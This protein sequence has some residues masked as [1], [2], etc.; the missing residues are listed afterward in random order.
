MKHSFL[1]ALLL[2]AHLAVPAQGTRSMT[3][4]IVVEVVDGRLSLSDPGYQLAAAQTVATWQLL[5]PGWRFVAA[6][7][8]FSDRGAPYDC[9]PY[10]QGMAMRCSKTDGASGRYGYTIALQNEQTGEVEVL[11]QPNGWIQND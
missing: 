5:T 4:P 3:P 7:I 6:S 1:A 8:R 2:G 9:S 11:P 10:A